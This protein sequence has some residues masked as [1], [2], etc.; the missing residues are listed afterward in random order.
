[1]K[2]DKYDLVIIRLMVCLIFGLGLYLGRNL[3]HDP[4]WVSGLVFIGFSMPFLI[5]AVRE[6][7]R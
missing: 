7:K 4:W 2:V 1:M 3:A 6:Y 5:G